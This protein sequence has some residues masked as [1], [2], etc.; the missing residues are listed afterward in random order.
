MSQC[1][2]CCNPPY[3][4]SACRE[5]CS[6]WHLWRCLKAGI[7]PYLRCAALFFHHLNGVRPPTG[8][9]GK[10]STPPSPYPLR[11]V[12]QP[13]FCMWTSTA[14]HLSRLIGCL[15]MPSLTRF[16][17]VDCMVTEQY[18]PIYLYLLLPLSP[19]LEP[20]W[21]GDSAQGCFGFGFV[22][23][24]LVLCAVTLTSIVAIADLIDRE[25]LIIPMH[26]LYEQ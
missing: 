17:I 6:G 8:L 16:H 4:C 1:W 3:C 7:L 21:G 11:T 20:E 10:N 25:C 15:K 9:Q 23:V 13:A 14:F 5:A 22:H 12:Y 18:I 26:L 19:P 2:F 24:D